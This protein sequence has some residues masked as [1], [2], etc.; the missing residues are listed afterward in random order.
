MPCGIQLIRG[1]YVKQKTHMQSREQQ[2]SSE[3]EFHQ[4]ATKKEH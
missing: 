1:F 2:S 4:V 3:T